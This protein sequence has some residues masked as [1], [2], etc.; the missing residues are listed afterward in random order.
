MR[1]R[2]RSSRASIRSRRGRSGSALL[3]HRVPDALGD[4]AQLA[5]SRG[6]GAGRARASRRPGAGRRPSTSADIAAPVDVLEPALALRRRVGGLG[7]RGGRRPGARAR[8]AHAASCRAPS[9]SSA[10]ISAIAGVRGGRCITSASRTVFFAPLSTSSSP[11]E[12]SKMSSGSSGVVNARRRAPREARA[13]DRRR[14]A[15]TRAGARPRSASPPAQATSA[16]IPSTRDRRLV[17]E[18]RRARRAS[19]AGTSVAVASCDRSPDEELTAPSA[20][21]AG[22]VSSQANA[23]EPTTRPA[24]VSP[25]PPAAADADDRGGDHLRRRDR[26]LPG[27]RHARIT[28]VERALAGERVDRRQP[29]DPAPDRAHDAPAA[30]RGAERQRRAAAELHPQRHRE[31]VDVGPSASSSAAITPIAFCASLAPWLNESAAD[32]THSPPRIGPRTRR[33]ARRSARRAKRTTPKPNAS[34]SGGE[35]ASAISTPSTPT[36]FKPSQP[37][38]VHR[39]ASP[40]RPT[41]RRPARR[42]TRGP[43]SRASPRHHVSRF[44]STAP[45]TPEP[46]TATACAGGDGDDAGDRARRR[47]SRRVARRAG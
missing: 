39:A 34:P 45:R 7:G 19:P 43:S 33:V 20:A 46:I 36:G 29:E 26:A 3:Q 35:T 18:H 27:R 30:E 13:C 15:R 5:R 1:S 12:S 4:L 44:Q 37:A 41:R 31:R 9:A 6:R 28:A 24:N 42:P 22:S 16:S 14:G 21:V 40:P 23:I 38:P 8:R 2:I 25:A 17:A 47:L 10:A 11:R 32:M